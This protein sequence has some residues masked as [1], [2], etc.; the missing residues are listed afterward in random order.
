MSHFKSLNTVA[1]GNGLCVC[2]FGAM[3]K[4]VV[5][6]WVIRAEMAATRLFAIVSGGG[7]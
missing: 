5:F 1:Q 7:D 4:L 3:F 2:N 6:F